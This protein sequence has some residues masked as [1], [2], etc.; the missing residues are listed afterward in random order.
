M[1]H[2]SNLFSESNVARSTVPF[3]SN[4]NYGTR[5]GQT[6]DI[7]GNDSVKKDSPIFV[8]IHGGY[9]QYL[10]KEV[11]AYCV[12]PLHKAGV[13]V[14]IPDYDLAPSVSLSIIVQ[15]I[16]ELALFI[17]KM[18]KED[19]VRDVWF[20]GH[21]AGAHLSSMLLS[22]EWLSKLDDDS[23]AIFKGLF[24]VSGVYN[25]RPLLSTT[26]NDAL[27]LTEKEIE[28]LSSMF[29]IDRYVKIHLCKSFRVVVAVGEH[30]SPL[31]QKQ[32]KDFHEVLLKSGILAEYIYVEG[33]D[34]FEIVENLSNA[35]FK[36]TKELIENFII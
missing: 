9:W 26:I 27:N 17:L 30:D 32:S 10:S 12:V 1:T 7:Y 5:E 15:E 22:T 34:H 11:S 25:L 3:K 31:F 13:R 2:K 16:F 21:S 23:K 33:V 14:V 20:G 24:L 18:A 19:G 6:F 8:Y 29:S 35:K 28:D 4:V 36:L